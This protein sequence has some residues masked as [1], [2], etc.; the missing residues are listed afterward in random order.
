MN[1]SKR[2]V[3]VEDTKRTKVKMSNV[4]SKRLFSIIGGIA[5]VIAI[6]AICIVIGYDS[7]HKD[8]VMTVDGKEF[9]VTDPEV[10]FTV[11]MQEAQL[12]QIGEQ[13]GS[14]F[15]VNAE[16]YFNAY[17]SAMKPQVLE[18]IKTNYVMY[19]E[20]VANGESLSEEDKKAT[21][22]EYKAIYEKMSDK[23]KSRLHMTSEQF[24]EQALKAELVSQYTE[25]LEEGYGVTKD[26]LETKIDKSKY[27][28]RSFEA[29]SVPLV[30]T[31]STGQTT[32][33]S[34]KEKAKYKKQMESYLKQAKEGKDMSKILASDEKTYRY[35]KKSLLTTDT[36][37][38][39]LMSKIKDMK[40]KEVYGK[41]IE[42]DKYY[43]VI[44]MTDND[45]TTQYDN[46]VEQQITTEK[47]TK[48]QNDI[49][50]AAKKHSFKE[51]K[52]W[53]KV[54]LGKVA[55]YPGESVEEFNPDTEEE[56]DT[57]ATETP[58]ATAKATN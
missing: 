26:T 47:A 45:V 54:E 5:A 18:S 15:N 25:K 32:P 46:A 48:L 17:A 12:E 1:K 22:E 23:R 52:G 21:E 56:D 39:E 3:R 51:Q 40:D 11:Y 44:K 8:P 37:Y 6:L 31:D 13:Y 55:V 29:I 36:T 14:M 28:E 42:A 4:D 19:E 58:K 24:V 38:P 9:Y 7:F 41:V 10:E 27:D 16:E 34:D 2:V 30:N 49:N 57:K 20:A 43:W 53:E 35:E 50:A 33:V